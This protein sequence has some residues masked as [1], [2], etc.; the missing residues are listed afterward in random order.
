M[1]ENSMITPNRETTLP[2]SQ[3]TLRR[4]LPKSETRTLGQIR[5][6]YE[7][8]KELADKL[9]HASKEER[10]YL[11]SFLYDEL[12]RRVPLHSMLTRKSSPA[13]TTRMVRLQMK[14]LHPFLNKEMTFLE[15]GPGD[16][17]L[18][19]EVS[20]F[21]KQVY[22]V[23][24][25]KEITK[26][27]MVPENF[28]LFLSDGCSLPVQPNSIDLAYSYLVMEHLHPDDA[29]DQ[30]QHIYNALAPDGTY[31]CI[32]PNRLTGPHDISKYFD[33]FA[34]GFHMKEYTTLEL[35]D[36]FKKVGFSRVRAYVGAKGNYVRFPVF[37]VALCE[38]F[39]DK[40]RY[41]IR[42][43]FTINLPLPLP[44][45]RLIGVK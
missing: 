45:I 25:S 43:V 2:E 6:H 39:L 29:F 15:V 31:I 28:Q 18:S 9:R 19:F 42:K 20:K 4:K 7:I 33:E 26:A 41:A 38:L 32:T 21:V 23:D 40:L 17:A 10:H 34:T 8:E 35:S 12:Y 37:P 3:K 36:L 27:S 5:E 13:Q 16:C 44:D 1:V 11:Y 30:L 14:F 24:V 22:A